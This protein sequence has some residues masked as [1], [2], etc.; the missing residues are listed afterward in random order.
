[1]LHVAMCA[2]GSP[3]PGRPCGTVLGFDGRSWLCW[4]NGGRGGVDLLAAGGGSV[5]GRCSAPGR[6]GCIGS[7]LGRARVAGCKR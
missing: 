6:S 7:L 2:N 1:M 3:S 4:I 5:V